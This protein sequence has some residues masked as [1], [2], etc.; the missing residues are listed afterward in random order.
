MADPVAWYDANAES[1]SARYEEVAPEAVHR[2]LL[3]LLPD[4]SAAVLDVGAGSGRDAAWL[5]RQGWDLVA[6]EPSAAMRAIAAR[7]HPNEAI[8]WIDDALPGLSVV[9]RSGLAFDLILLSAVWMHVPKRDR[10]RA[11]RKLINLL[12]P[13]GLLAI[14]LRQGPAEPERSIYPVTLAEIEALARDHGAFVERSKMECDHLGRG[15]VHWT[16]VAVRLPDD[17][18]GALPLLRHA[19]L[20][21]DKASTYK[22]ALLRSLCRIADGAAGF[23]RDHDDDFISLPLGL[24]ALTWVRLFK[25]LLEASLPQ[26]PSNVGFERLGFV[27]EAFRKLD[28][29]SHLDLRVGMSFSG[30]NCAALHQS[31]KD[32]AGTITRMPAKYMTFPSG[33]PILQVKRIGRVSRPSQLRLDEAYLSSFGE[34]LVPRHLWRALQRFDAWIEPALVAEWIR[35]TKSYSNG[36]GR[37]INDGTIAAAMTWSEPLRDVRIA[38]DQCSRLLETGALYCVWSGKRLSAKNVDLDHCFPWSAWPCGDLWNLMPT[39]RSVNQREKRARLPGDKIMRASQNRIMHWWEIAYTAH[40]SLLNDRFQLEAASS[41]PGVTSTSNCLEDIFDAVCLQRM[42]LK[43][44]QQ[45][46]EWYGDAYVTFSQPRP[47]PLQV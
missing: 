40:N 7:L 26:S 45:V 8:R 31:I 24:V 42:R 16:Q 20:N 35:L 19:I 43:Y 14:T 15:D 21:D 4:R 2:W 44:D 11:F 32:A 28:E 33:G 18:T 5:A 34:M 13:G 38:R 37:K 17:G 10:A 25:P 6:V 41:L 30:K 46:P 39:H 9:T 3:D 23:A 22:L 29:V 27:K 1:V 47:P 12:K 36:Q